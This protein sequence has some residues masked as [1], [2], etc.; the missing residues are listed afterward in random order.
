M[1][2]FSEINVHKR[3]VTEEALKRAF[4]GTDEDLLTHQFHIFLPVRFPTSAIEPLNTCSS[5]GCTTVTALVT[6]NGKI[7]IVCYIF[8]TQQCQAPDFLHIRQ[9]QVTQDWSLVSM[10]K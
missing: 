10:A 5:A 7:C 9:K 4:L 6:A 3:F 8:S 2:K 1:A